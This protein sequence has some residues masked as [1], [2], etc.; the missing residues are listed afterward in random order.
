MRMF[1][2]SLLG[3]CVALAACQSSTATQP[4]LALAPTLSI[5]DA[6]IETEST[7]WL[8]PQSFLA[9]AERL[10]I[11]P[12]ALQVSD[13]NAQLLSELPGRFETL[14]H[15]ADAGG[16]LVATLDKKRQQ[17]LVARLQGDAWGSAHYLPKTRF[18][19]E[20][21]CLY[22]D[23][24]RNDYLFL[25]GEEGIGEQWLVAE[26]GRP[27]NEARQVRALSLPPQSGFCQVDDR[28]ES[29]YV[30]E[31]NVGVWRYQA[32]AE[33]PLVREPVELLAPFG[34]LVE[35][36]AGMA[37]LPD[38]LLLL[39]SAAANL[40]LYQRSAG[41]WQ[42]AGVVKLDGLSEPEQ[43]SARATSEGLELL[44]GDDDGARTAMLSWTP[45][46][47]PHAPAIAQVAP[48]VQTD[49]VP[50][51][52]D[53]AD[54]PA[55]WVN[56]R[57]PERSR[58]LGTDKKG[59]LLAYDLAGKQVQSL[60]VGR[61]NNV[62]IRPGFQLGNR[63]VDL[64]VASN[65]DH[66]SL[67]LFAIDQTSGELSDIGQLATPLEDIYGLCLFKDRQGAIHAIANDKDGTF[68]QYR[69]TGDS[70]KATGQ[71]VR[72]FKTE[73]Q[74]EGCVA[75]DRNERLYI[76]EENV[77]VWALDARSDAQAALEKVIAIG[78]PLK[79]DIEGLGLYH[80]KQRDYLVISSQGNDSYVVVEALAPYT[81]RGSFK[82][83]LNAGLGIDG[84]SQTDGLEVTSA[85]LGGPW[86][87]GMLV[88]QDGRKR[89][90]EGT[91]NYKYVPWSAVADALGLE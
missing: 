9:N 30:N 68:L 39:D 34:A 80:G 24:V 48:L 5:N 2:L 16:L 62:D 49:G 20:G 14:D 27:L 32:G 28:S 29:L 55:I 82:V 19:I 1:N 78:G 42:R 56:T 79:D 31:E 89:M 90:P 13:R 70:G 26:N 21:L 35:R 77:A 18:A 44:L 12:K 11:G 61:L 74:P 52:G 65:R 69:L 64:A 36:A 72:R 73:T 10:Q 25:V 40:H 3:L 22:R 8:A 71:L 59:G 85:N 23:S 83:G 88:V 63:Q 81:L 4:V 17:A 6:L 41:Q 76:G 37:V 57:H 53:A 33:A 54:D 51:L 91:Q 38:G 75:D 15:R 7:Q 66:H 60:R 47:T 50:S 45:Q 67:H 46:A 58:V 87:A 43:V 84:A 86:S